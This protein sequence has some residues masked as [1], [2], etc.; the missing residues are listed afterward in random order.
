MGRSMSVSVDEEFSSNRRVTSGVPQ[1]SGL[2]PVLFLI[3]I[4]FVVRKV[5][6][7]WVAFADNFKLVVVYFDVGHD[8]HNSDSLQEDLD[9][10]SRI[11][12]SWN[13]RLKADKYAA[14]HFGK[15]NFDSVRYFVEGKR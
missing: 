13:L 6:S 12:R 9:S 5:R 11:G 15:N 10:V 7:F 14:M 1:G 3:Y 8:R 2:V 4:N